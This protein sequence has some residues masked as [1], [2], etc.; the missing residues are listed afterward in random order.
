MNYKT[1]LKIITWNVR[2]LNWRS[3]KLAVRK[4]IFLEK[5]D[6][7]YIQETKLSS[8]DDT[9]KKEICGRRLDKYEYVPAIGTRGGMLIAWRSTRFQQQAATHNNYCLTVGLKDMMLYHSI[10]CTTV[11]GLSS[12]A[13][14]SDF[15]M[16]L[17]NLKPKDTI[18]WLI[19]GDFN[20]TL[21]PSDRNTTTQDWRWPTAF[22]DLISNLEV[23]NIQMSGRK[24]TWDNT[25]DQPSMAKLDRFLLSNEWSTTFPNTK[26]KT[27]PNTSSDHCPI[28]IEAF[29]D[30][31]KTKVFRFE[32]FWL[33]IVGFKDIVKEEWQSHPMTSTPAQ[34]HIKLQ[35]LQ[36]KIIAWEKS[37]VGNI[38]AQ[39]EVCRQFIA[40]IEEIQERS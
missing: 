27:L 2:G 10:Q 18:P 16:E 36:S 1:K 33:S 3:K 37:K 8:I 15:F 38:R 30:F 11:Y 9:T 17:Q 40:W 23:Q 14:K 24:C 35:Q 20:V 25:R 5:P 19:G 39:I 29:T 32:K 21:D 34:M 22:V 7:V 13:G 28:M 4:T 12:P 6:I 26:Q 31:Q